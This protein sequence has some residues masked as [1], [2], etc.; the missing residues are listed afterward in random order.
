MTDIQRESLA[1]ESYI[2][3]S[4]ENSKSKSILVQD[5]FV[6]TQEQN[7]ENEIT[8]NENEDTNPIFYNSLDIARILGCSKPTAYQVMHRKDFPLI[9]AGNR[10]KVYKTAM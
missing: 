10:L 6:L 5:E 8:K 4:Y 1:Q 2:N 9:K 3:T 7:V